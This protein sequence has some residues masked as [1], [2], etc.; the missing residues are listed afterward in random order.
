MKTAAFNAVCP[1]EIGDKVRDGNTGRVRTITD[2]ACT[3]YLK[4]GKVEFYYELDNSGQY[5]TIEFPTAVEVKVTFR[6]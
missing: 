4:A 5:I 2:I 6:K 3:H 1:V